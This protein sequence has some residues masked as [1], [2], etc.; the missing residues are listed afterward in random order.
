MYR[1]YEADHEA[2]GLR[3]WSGRGT[4]QLLAFERLA[5]HTDALLLERCVPGTTAAA[6]DEAEQDAVVTALLRRLW[7]PAPAGPFRPL[8]S[9]CD[10]WAD[11]L[12]VARANVVVGDPGVVRAGVALFR[13]L[14]RDW[15]GPDVLL[16]TDLHADNVL[17]A[18]REPWLA[19]DAKPYVGDPT[20][21]PLQHML[22]CPGRLHGN[23]WAFTRHL[24]GLLDLD[25]KRLAQWLF[26]RC[27][28]ECAEYPELGAVA[29]MLA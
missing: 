14:P 21:D 26:A 23:P 15:P 25:A 17:A 24:A 13:G 2:D 12:D 29:R 16:A 10:A 3:A 7:I 9:M 28:I 8:A 22:N 18:Q 5:E 20:Y 19:I 6:L 11:K 1:H 27:V 4:V